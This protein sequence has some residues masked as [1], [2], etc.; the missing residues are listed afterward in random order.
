MI[1][2]LHYPNH[3]QTFTFAIPVGKYFPLPANSMHPLEC[4]LPGFHLP[5]S[6]FIACSHLH[7]YI[8]CIGS[9]SQHVWLFDQKT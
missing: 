7:D 5:F 6:S 8:D 4:N 3:F 2:A 1:C 9:L